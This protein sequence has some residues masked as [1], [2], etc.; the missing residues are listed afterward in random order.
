MPSFRS[1]DFDG[2]HARTHRATFQST[3]VENRFLQE[4]AQSDALNESGTTASNTKHRKKELEYKNKKR[5]RKQ[6]RR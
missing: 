2:S 5:L 6:N 4:V 1:I 3:V